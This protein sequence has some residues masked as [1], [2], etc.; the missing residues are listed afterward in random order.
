[1]K[2]KGGSEMDALVAVVDEIVEET[3]AMPGAG[4]TAVLEDED[5]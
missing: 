5:A 2:A 1:M 4:T 3:A